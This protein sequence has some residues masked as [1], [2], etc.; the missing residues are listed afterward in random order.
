[1]TLA[2]LIRKTLTHLQREI[3]MDSLKIDKL[4]KSVDELKNLNSKE[5]FR[6]TN[7][8][9]MAI[10]KGCNQFDFDEFDFF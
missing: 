1:M 7:S 2:E 3:Q 9:L 4:W 8:T 6:K 10:I 5:F